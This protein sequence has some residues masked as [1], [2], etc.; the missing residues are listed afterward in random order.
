MNIKFLLSAMEHGMKEFLI[1]F[2]DLPSF[3]AF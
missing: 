3:Y 1:S 2:F